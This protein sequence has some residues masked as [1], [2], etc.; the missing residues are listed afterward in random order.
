M[1]AHGHMVRSLLIMEIAGAIRVG[2]WVSVGVWVRGIRPVSVAVWVG[3]VV[4]AIVSSLW[5]SLGFTLV[6]PVSVASIAISRGGI[7]IRVWSI[8]VSVGPQAIGGAIGGAISVGAWG[9]VAVVVSISLWLSLSITLVQ[10]VSVASIAISRAGIAIRVWSIVVSIGPQTIA[11]IRVGAWGIVAV[12][13][14][15]SLWFSLS[16]TL[17][18]PVVAVSIGPVAI[19]W[20]TI[21]MAIAGVSWIVPTVTIV[22]PAEVSISLW[23]CISAGNQCNKQ[24]QLHD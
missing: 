19:S 1:I 23:F 7:A 24:Q 13:V 21:A 22:V 6:Q 2:T 3:V 14:S 10:P 16:I 17:V 9:I 11:A 8:V 5:L 18:E 20:V 12:V 4:P 15:I